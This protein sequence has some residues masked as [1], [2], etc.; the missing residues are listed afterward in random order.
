MAAL[1]VSQQLSGGTRE[2]KAKEQSMNWGLIFATCQ[3]ILSVLASIGYALVLDFK[4]ATY[5]VFAAGLTSVVTWWL[6]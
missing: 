6:K 3:I 2:A 1:Q 5:W 4:H